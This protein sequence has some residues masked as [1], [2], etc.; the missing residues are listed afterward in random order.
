MANAKRVAAE[1]RGRV[2]EAR[3]AWLLRLKGYS[4]V[5][6][7]FRPARSFG[8]GEIDLVARRGRM[9][10]FV[11][12]KARA[13]DAEALLAITAQ[14]QHRIL[15]AAEHFLK[16]RPVYTGWPMRFDAVILEQDRFWPRHF[17]DAWRP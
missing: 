14:Q 5:A 8:L 9:L 10:A 16:V 4:I 12:V 6:R 13:T 7:R 17:P 11:E 3:A 2:A 15:R 1:G